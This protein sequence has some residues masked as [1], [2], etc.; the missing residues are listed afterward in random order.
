MRPAELQE[1]IAAE[2]R[3]VPF[4]YLRADEERH[5]LVVPLPSERL[6][7]GRAPGSDLAITWDP[8]VSAVHAYLERRGAR[9]TV[10]DD[11]LSRNGTFVAGDRLHG[12]RALRDGDVIQ[13]GDTL[14]GFRDPVPEPVVETVAAPTLAAPEVSEAQRRVLVALCR[15]LADGSRATPATNDEIAHELFLSLAAVKSH[16]RAL[17]ERFGLEDLP[18]NEKRVQLAD[19]ALA[20]GAVHPEDLASRR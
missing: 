13:V 9:W 3:G 10:E 6:V 8:R 14:I 11:G 20:T 5:L 1:L 15:P 4:L 19:R 18:Q 16:L 2:R 17:F 7:V 12:Q